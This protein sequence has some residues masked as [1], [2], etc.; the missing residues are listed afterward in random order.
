MKPR[1][2]GDRALEA[3]L[4]GG[5]DDDFDDLAFVDL[6]PVADADG[7]GGAPIS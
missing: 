6:V 3:A 7:G 4:V 2:F 1:M 5:G